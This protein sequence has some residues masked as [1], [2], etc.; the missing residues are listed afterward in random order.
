MQLQGKVALVTG[1]SRGIGA[2]VVL[3]LAGAGA[4]VAINYQQHEGAAL[5]VKEEVEARGGKAL[6]CR[7]D[8]TGLAECEQM[9]GAVL[10]YFGRIDILV[11][12]A[13]IRRDNILAMMKS[14]DWDAVI[15]TNLKGVFNSCKAVLKPLLKQKS[16]GR[17]VN[18]ASVPGLSG[19]S[20]QTNYAAAK[21]GVIAFTKSLAKEL[22]KR[23][24]TVNAVAPGFIE[25]E[26]TEG[27]PQ[28]IREKVRAQIALERL[29]KP[30]EVAA[31]VLFL[32][33]ESSSYIT[34]AVLS[35]DGGLT[36]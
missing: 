36:L 35:I 33:G 23:E 16:G 32:A 28:S 22:G 34:G 4:A 21:A 25:T 17:I 19:N 14:A 11:N 5:L 13:G 31:A 29:G 18:I 3:A 9:V 20:G 30:A 1:G 24:I 15:D 26:M 6:L 7:A 27:L 2:A 10:E 8:V 12:N